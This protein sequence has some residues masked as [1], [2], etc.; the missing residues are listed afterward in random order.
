MTCPECGTENPDSAR[1]C[2][3][4]GG[5]LSAAPECPDCGTENPR[6]QAFCNGCGR[7]LV[8]KEPEA[9][10]PRSYTPQH[11]VDKIAASAATLEGE[12]KQVTVL[13]ADVAGSMELAD[14]VDPESWRSIMD[15]FYALVGECVNR[16]EGTVNKFTGDGAMALFGAPIAHEDHARRACYAVLHLRDELEE[17]ARSVRREHG[18]GFSVRMGLN[19]GEVVVGGVG[20]DLNMDYTAIGNTVGLAARMEALSEPGKPY[21]TKDTA[22]LVEGYFELE[23]VGELQVKGVQAPV[24][25]YALAGVGSARTRLDVSAGRGLSRFVGRA[26]E[27]EA[28]KSAYER[29]RTS[30]HVVGVVA[31]AGIGKSRLCREFV[32][33]CRCR[34]IDVTE[35]RGVA[36]GRR[37]PLLPVVDML[38]NYFGVEDDDDGRLAREKIAG[39]LLLID[40]SFRETLPVLFEFMG[41]ADPDRPAPQ[42]APEARERVLFGAIGRLVHARAEEGGGVVLVED[43][44][45][46]DPGSEAFLAHLIGSLPGTR[47]LA[48]VNFR[49][50]YA[51]AWMKKSYYE[52]LPLL[53]LPREAIAAMVRDLIGDDASLDGLVDLVAER[54]GGNPF[55]I[56][57]VVLALVD[58]GSLVGSR[59]AYR[60]AESIDQLVIPPTVQA[61]LSARIDRLDER[62]K[63]VLQAASVIGC[64]FSEPV[65][66][67]VTGLEPHELIESLGALCAAEHVFERTMYPFPQY[68]FKHP[69]TE[70]VAYR[71]QLGG[72]R[73]RTHAAVAAALEELDADRLDEVAGLLSNHWEQAG[74]PLKAARWGARAAT[75]AGQSHPADA[76]R[77]WRRVRTLL[78]SS[79]DDPDAAELVLGACLWTLQFGWR[80]G[81]SDDEVEEVWHTGLDL[82]ERS[83]NDWA[84]IAL[85]GSHAVSRGMVGAV[86]EALE[87][88][89]EAKRL[90]QELG[91]LSLEMSVGVP[92]WMDLL[93]D[94]RGALRE[95]D[96]AIAKMGDDYKL[97]RDV[98]G[99]SALIWCTFFRSQL[100]A[101][102]G[103]LDEARATAGRAMQ[104]AREHD[105]I[106]SL[107]W[108]HNQH[109]LFDYYVG[110][111]RDG[112]E[113]ARKGVELAEQTHS[114]FSRATAYC[115]LGYGHLSREE[116]IEAIEAEEEA[117]RIM[118]DTRTGMQYEP[119]S[120]A[121][122]AEAQLAL[123]DAESARDMARRG[124]EVAARYGM[125]THESACRLILGRASIESDPD[126]ARAELERALELTGDDWSCLAPQVHEALGALDGE[127]HLREAL[128]L[129]ELTG[130]HGHAR[131]LRAQA[132]V[133]L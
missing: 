49:P 97:G 59:G 84:K 105:D 13:F 83:G 77:H 18:L 23:D 34:Q 111:P 81:L 15:R 66:S 130:A 113:H 129:Y 74:D 6:G 86:A 121:A 112:L 108:S 117:L 72:R 47:T 24:H 118:R 116:W 10:A 45:W 101:E 40:E 29:S 106:E 32:E 87:H 89:R 54:T 123:G 122:I 2:G 128:R 76:L 30:G 26:T 70:E 88:A 17:Y 109:A 55:F 127:A 93:G 19:S 119:L 44:H 28:L 1:F 58:S 41:V 73:A 48:I 91:A 3:G 64:E 79:G 27:L 65:L 80:Q 5:S 57:E 120:L 131:R 9:P 102:R 35:G 11:L 126:A 114:A 33:W 71:T 42:M 53:P 43:L 61:V 124:A 69:L 85:Y 75:W 99:F 20:D 94:T 68:V 132:G 39:R 115:L 78:S 56:E 67:R 110:E 52:R 133:M 50:E 21:L 14:S 103:R 104:L 90:A 8:E 95:I 63:S 22:A 96:E 4:C 125:R 60:L 92:Y 37:I 107:G 51:A 46:L 38:R 31:E 62:D 98:I 82:A 7:R 25:A 12:R 100:L 16:F 36:H